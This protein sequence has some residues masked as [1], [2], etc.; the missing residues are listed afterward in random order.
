MTKNE[1]LRISCLVGIVFFMTEINGFAQYKFDKNEVFEFQKKE[2]NWGLKFDVQSE[3]EETRTKSWRE[4]EEITTGAAKL[5]FNNR[6][7][8]FAENKQEQIDLNFEAG[9][10]WGRGNWIDSSAIANTEV[11]QDIFGLRTYASAK[12]SSRFYY[13]KKITPLYRLMAGAFTIFKVSL[14]KAC[15]PTRTWLQLLL[16]LKALRINSGLTLVDV[17]GGD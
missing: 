8:N 3:R 15:Q 5:Q 11:D 10:L 7:W 14:Q 1:I 2:L 13:N 9:P 12:Y 17:Q 6:Y 16:I 4:F